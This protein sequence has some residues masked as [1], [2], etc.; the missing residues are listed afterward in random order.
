MTKISLNNFVI[1]YFI[2]KAACRDVGAYTI[3]I[4]IEMSNK[5]EQDVSPLVFNI[6]AGMPRKQ[7]NLTI[8]NKYLTN[9]NNIHGF[10]LDPSVIQ[11]ALSSCSA[12]CDM[13][14]DNT[15]YNIPPSDTWP[16]NF[17]FNFIASKNIIYPYLNI[18]SNRCLITCDPSSSYDFSLNESGASIGL[19]NLKIE[20]RDSFV[21]MCLDSNY[22][23]EQALDFGF[24]YQSLNNP[25]IMR[26]LFAFSVNYFNED[27]AKVDSFIGLLQM[28]SDSIASRKWFDDKFPVIKTARTGMD[29]NFWIYGL[30][31]KMLA[32]A[33]GPDYSITKKWAPIRN[34]LWSFIDKERKKAG[35]SGATLEF[36]LKMKDHGSSDDTRVIQSLIEEMR[37]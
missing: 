8:V 24:I 2:I 33:R 19:R 4:S 35:L 15:E 11:G 12:L 10:S 13:Y 30:I 7:I 21:M 5:V 34:D 16:E 9:F 3:D 14:F 20:F 36:M 22:K 26:M 32:P 17:P 25:D 27:V 28:Y 31:E 23:R 1:P 6:S 37:A 18:S 29:G